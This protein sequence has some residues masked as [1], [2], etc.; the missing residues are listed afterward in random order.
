[1]SMKKICNYI[2]PLLLAG[3]ICICG[4][5]RKQDVLLYQENS[6]IS[7]SQTTEPVTMLAEPEMICVYVCGAVNQPGIAELPAGARVYQAVEFCGGLTKEA[8]EQSLNHAAILEDGMQ[9]TV[10]TKAEAETAVD[11]PG[12]EVQDAGEGKININHATAE[13]LKTLPGIGDAKAADI[14]Q[15]REQ[16]GDFQSIDEIKNISGIKDAVFEKI[17][18]KIT[19]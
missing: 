17:K 5:E 7:E 4:C 1:M 18:D 11:V 3:V 8:D 10:L 9:V 19:V 14:I 13:E 6:G 16:T 2:K 12:N 15:Y